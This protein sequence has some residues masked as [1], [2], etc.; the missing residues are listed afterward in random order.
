MSIDLERITNPLRLA[1]GSH[2]KGSGRGCAM[3]VIS[4]I[5]GDAEITDFPE[6]SAV[7]LARMVQHVNDILG[8]T[9]GDQAG[10][11]DGEVIEIVTFLSPADSFTVLDLAWSTVGTAVDE[12]DPAIAVWG[13]RVIQNAWA[14]YGA[15]DCDS[16]D[17]QGILYS[18]AQDG[19]TGNY[20]GVAAAVV[21]AVYTA[22]GEHALIVFVR[23]AIALW[24]ELHGQNETTEADPVVVNEAIERMVTV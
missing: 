7:P 9:N 15:S 10:Y 20:L 4:F 19:L 18:A 24:K 12:D 6:C 5:I 17:P 21:T 1:T 2:P 23:D 3:N 11:E 8:D 22:A 16:K 14:V 13:R